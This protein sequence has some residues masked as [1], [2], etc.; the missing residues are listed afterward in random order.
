M[1]KTSSQKRRSSVT[2]EL[3]ELEL[4]WETVSAAVAEDRQG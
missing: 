3:R 1:A 2:N 4:S